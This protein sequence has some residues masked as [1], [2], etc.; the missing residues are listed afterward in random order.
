MPDKVEQ[1]MDE[2]PAEFAATTVEGDA[3]FTQERSGVYGAVRVPQ[4]G[5]PMNPNRLSGKGRQP[6]QHGARPRSVSPMVEMEDWRGRHSFSEY[7]QPVR[8]GIDMK[9]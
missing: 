8:E 9:P 4:A 5:L 2:D 6:Q 1:L 7:R 3:A